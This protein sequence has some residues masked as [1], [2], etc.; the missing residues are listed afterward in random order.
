M[1]V[2]QIAQFEKPEWITAS[3][4]PARQA[5]AQLQAQI[6]AA[7]AECERLELPITRARA[8]L[9]D[10]EQASRQIEQERS[11][12]D[13]DE[14]EALVATAQGGDVTGNKL[15]RDFARRRADLDRRSSQLAHR[16]EL[17]R[18]AL[19]TVTQPF[20]AARVALRDLQ[21]GLVSLVAEIAG[22][23]HADAMT[24]RNE[25]LRVAID[26]EIEARALAMALSAEG[27]RLRSVDAAATP[28]FRSAGKMAQTYTD[29]ARYDPPSPQQLYSGAAKWTEWLH[30]ISN[31]PDA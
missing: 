14:V 9:T 28:L 12:T 2:H 5:L 17:A 20:D 30:A 29:A 19:E 1:N 15:A 26:A 18:R 21:T 13:A 3:R 7:A 8:T 10:A 23:L 4:S 27:D 24:R 6:T 16:T 25:A 31:D 11:S 22:E